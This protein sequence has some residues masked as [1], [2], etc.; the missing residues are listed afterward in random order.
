[1]LQLHNKIMQHSDLCITHEICDFTLYSFVAVSP[2]E[3]T[4]IVVSKYLSI[5]FISLVSSFVTEWA[6]LKFGVRIDSVNNGINNSVVKCFFVKNDFC[7][8]QSLID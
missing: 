3:S 8:T 7:V 6:F 1:M 2:S 5:P 4:S